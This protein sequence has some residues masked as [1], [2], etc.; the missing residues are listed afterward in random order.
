MLAGRSGATL[1]LM[2][3]G[4]IS[5]PRVVDPRMFVVQ[6]ARAA[7]S[8]GVPDATRRENTMDSKNAE[9]AARIAVAFN[10]RDWEAIRAEVADHCVFSD[11]VQDHKGAD[12]FVDGYNKGW[13]TG[14]SDAK[15]TDVTVHDAGDT[16]IVEFLGTGT[17]DGPF[18]DLPATGEHT[19]QHICEVYR[20][21]PDGKVIGGRSYYDQLDILTQLGH[22]ES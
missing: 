9:T 15:M 8:A 21:G 17:N 16:V 12:G 22:A 19:S 1:G 13:V 10:D 2:S 4:P 3:K 7:I 18:G 11:P 14:F 5:T 20:F 6:I